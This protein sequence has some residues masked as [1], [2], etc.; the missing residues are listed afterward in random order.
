LTS[1]KCSSC[2]AKGR[3]HLKMKYNLISQIIIQIVFWSVFFAL[4]N[5]GTTLALT[6]ALILS[7]LSFV[8]FLMLME[9]K[10]LE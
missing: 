8:P 2:G 9:F 5:S 7:L 10:A 1:T 3:A 4:F 6:S